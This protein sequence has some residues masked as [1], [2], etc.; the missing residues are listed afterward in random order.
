M[1]DHILIQAWNKFLVKVLNIVYRWGGEVVYDGDTPREEIEEVLVN[2][3]EAYI[4]C[5]A[6]NTRTDGK[7]GEVGVL[8]SQSFRT[9]R[10]EWPR[11]KRAVILWYLTSYHATKQL[12]AVVA[13][14]GVQ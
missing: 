9:W 6:K 7:A 14:E 4:G 10:C 8:A 13:L 12:E 5:L 3:G 1:R 2:K 11:I